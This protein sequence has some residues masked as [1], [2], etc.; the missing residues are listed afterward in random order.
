MV[1]GWMKMKEGEV[2]RLEADFGLASVFACFVAQSV[3]SN[4]WL[5]VHFVAYG[6]IRC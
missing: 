4:W 5:G 2:G 3:M 1:G 6:V